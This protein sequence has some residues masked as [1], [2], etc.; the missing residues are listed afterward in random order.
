M[1]TKTGTVSQCYAWNADSSLLMTF[2]V[3]DTKQPG[4][5]TDRQEYERLLLAKSH[6]FP[7]TVMKVATLL[8]HPSKA[9]HLVWAGLAEQSTVVLKNNNH[10]NIMQGGQG[11]GGR[12]EHAFQAALDVTESDSL[13]Q[14]RRF[15]LLLSPLPP[16]PSAPSP[17]CPA[18]TSIA[19]FA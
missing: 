15:V 7:V 1:A 19:L 12:I 13:F 2:H 5:P 10:F 14:P 8:V 11:S 6:V 17:T 9:N 18:A 3:G 16:K 4:P